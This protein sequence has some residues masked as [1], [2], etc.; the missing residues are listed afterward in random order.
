MTKYN[1]AY[2]KLIN[3]T[4]EWIHKDDMSIEEVL[5]LI[6]TFRESLKFSFCNYLAYHAKQQLKEKENE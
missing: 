5:G 1:E 4:N 2:D 6:S 3:I